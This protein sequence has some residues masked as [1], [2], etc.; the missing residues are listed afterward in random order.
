VDFDTLLNKNYIKNIASIK[1]K[2][3]LDIVLEIADIDFNSKY[4]ILINLYDEF[5][6]KFAIDN[7]EKQ[8]FSLEIFAKLLLK[9]LIGYVKISKVLFYDKNAKKMIEMMK[10]LEKSYGVKVI[11]KH[12]ENQDLYDDALRNDF[13]YIQGYFL[14]T[15]RS[16]EDLLIDQN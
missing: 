3:G 4:Q 7:F 15:P 5:G 11:V 2:Y 16:L 12:I 13:E 8:C 10:F 6:V 1:E 14:K 9:G